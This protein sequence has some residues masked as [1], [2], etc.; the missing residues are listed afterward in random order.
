MKKILSIIF[1]AF[2]SLSIFTGCSSDN[3]TTTGGTSTTE[4]GTF[5]ASDISVTYNGVTLTPNALFND[6]AIAEEYEY[7]EAQ[8]CGFVGLDKI[9]TY[10]DIEIYTYP[11]G[12]KDYILEI[13][14]LTTSETDKGIKVGNT[15]DDIMTAYGE[16][17]NDDSRTVEYVSGDSSLIF[18]LT[19][20][21][22]ID[23][24]RYV[25]NY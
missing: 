22:I 10:N 20:S 19:S 4:T 24:I 6:T 15:Y 11:D 9:Y 21:G 7:Y 13:N 25:Y 8:S 5:A 12:D 1:L 14:L 16:A 17:T 18:S 2:F 3:N 23:E